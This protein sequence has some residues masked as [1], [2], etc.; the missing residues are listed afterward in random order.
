VVALLREARITSCSVSNASATA[1]P[2]VPVA[3]ITMILMLFP[4]VV[5]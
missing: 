2:M 4:F 5:E 1:R 3:P